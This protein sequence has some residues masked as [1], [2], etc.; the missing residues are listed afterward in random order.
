M[1]CPPTLFRGADILFTNAHDIHRLTGAVFVKFSRSI[2]MNI[3]KIVATRCKILRLNAP[4][5]ILLGELTPLPRPP[6][7]I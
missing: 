3:I 1:F 2:L 7:C 5:S 6:S 4:N